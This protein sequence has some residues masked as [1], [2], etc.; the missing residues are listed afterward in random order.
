MDARNA[1]AFL[2]GGGESC[3]RMR[4]YGI[5]RHRG[6]PRTW[7]QSRRTVAHI[8]LDSRH[9]TW[10]LCVAQRIRAASWDG[11]MLLIAVTDWGQSEDKRRAHDAGSDH[12]FTKPLD[13]DAI[14]GFLSDALA[15]PRDL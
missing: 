4:A 12:H 7:P 1:I 3:A 11:S 9:S 8:M 14:G 5:G 10:M 2:E 15:G 6:A 13:L